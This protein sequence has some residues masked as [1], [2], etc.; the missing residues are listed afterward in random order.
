MTRTTV[1]FMLTVMTTLDQ[2]LSTRPTFSL[3]ELVN[4]A[5]GLLSALLP[6]TSDAR[7]KEE[8]NP[9]LIRHYTTQGLLETPLRV[10]REA[11]YTVDH[12]LQLLA[13][14]HLL[15]KGVPASSIGDGLVKME[16]ERLRAI[17]E[18]EA[19]TAVDLTATPR[20]AALERLSAIRSRVASSDPANPVTK[21]LSSGLPALGGRRPQPVGPSTPEN[22]E[23]YVLFDGVEL[24]VRDDVKVPTSLDA[25]RRLLDEITR[26][27]IQIAQRRM[28]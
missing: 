19:G 16:R 13:L 11:R 22:W 2:L 26:L 10:G 23:R 8:V 6:E 15:A 5:N 21:R 28:T 24:H 3:D 18:G 7:I 17:I 20:T 9:R 1:S 12:L 27:L 4:T 14:R 25:Q